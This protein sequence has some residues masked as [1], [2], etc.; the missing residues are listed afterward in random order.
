M[1]HMNLGAG[2]AWTVI[3]PWEVMLV[4]W[5]SAAIFTRRTVA[6][7]P[8][9]ERAA[10]LALAIAAFLL[11]FAAGWRWG[12]LASPLFRTPARASYGLG[13]FLVWLGIGWALWARAWL[14]RYWSGR[15]T[16]KED[17]RLIRGGPYALSRHPIYTGM[18]LAVAGTALAL[19][20][21]RGVL[22]LVAWLWFLRVKIRGEE[23]LL[24]SHF[25]PAYENYRRQVP[26]L[27]PLSRRRSA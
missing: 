9:R 20:Q 24:T 18:L 21:W 17:H 11:L 2:F 27:L 1:M 10:Q 19:N 15:P 22:A 8:A 6:A 25:G 3:A 13:V 23:R 12:P 7:A 16:L 26:A 4:V 14:G 5:A